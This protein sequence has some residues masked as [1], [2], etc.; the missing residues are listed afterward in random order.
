MRAIGV[1]N[2]LPEHLER[3]VDLGLTVPAVNQVEVHP[4]FAQRDVR[5]A[6]ARYGILTQAWS[7]L[8]Q[9]VVLDNPTVAQIAYRHGKT[10]AQVV[11]RWHHGGRIGPDL[12]QLH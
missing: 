10:P 2:F 4:E 8:A 7:P 3:V 6:N 1:S 12:N 9:S 5:H 11:L